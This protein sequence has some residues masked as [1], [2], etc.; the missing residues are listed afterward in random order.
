MML[1]GDIYRRVASR[2]RIYTHGQFKIDRKHVC[3]IVYV[4]GN[5]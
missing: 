1:T 4:L 2:D 3:I 5:L